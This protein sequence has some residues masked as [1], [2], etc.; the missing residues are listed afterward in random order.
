MPLQDRT[1][2]VFGESIGLLDPHVEPTENNVI[3]FISKIRNLINI[4]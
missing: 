1:K 4:N 3:R 2:Y